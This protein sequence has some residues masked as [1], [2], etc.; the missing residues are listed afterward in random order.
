MPQRQEGKEFRSAERKE[1]VSKSLL[2]TCIPPKTQQ[3][4]RPTARRGRDKE[5]KGTRGKEGRFLR[6]EQ[7]PK[8]SP[9]TN[10][11]GFLERPIGRKRGY[12]W[13][14]RKNHENI[15]RK[16]GDTGAIKKEKADTAPAEKSDGARSGNLKKF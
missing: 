8:R 11:K 13:E 2:T 14:D 5:G 12:L 7:E 10:R 6:T 16:G 3:R 4:R 9:G 15:A 1:P